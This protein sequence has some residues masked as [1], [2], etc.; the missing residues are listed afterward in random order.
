MP[1]DKKFDPIQVGLF[2]A[3]AIVLVTQ[4]LPQLIKQMGTIGGYRGRV[5]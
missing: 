4:D 5:S 1:T 3:Q 2:G